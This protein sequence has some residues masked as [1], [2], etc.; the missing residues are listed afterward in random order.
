MR[1]IRTPLGLLA[2]LLLLAPGCHD[3][4]FEPRGGAG[5]ID[6]Y[7]DLFSVSTPDG[8][9]VLAS[10][11][12]GSIYRSEDGGQSWARTDRWHEMTRST[13]ARSEP[14]RRNAS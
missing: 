3:V 9:L 2:V 14:L 8:N 13:S 10:G 12:W 4:H 6:I 7:D 11:Y 1:A 5:D